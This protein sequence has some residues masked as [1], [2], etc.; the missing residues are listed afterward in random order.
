MASDAPQEFRYDAFI[1]Y[2]HTEPDR[3]WARWLHAALETYRVPRRLV[4]ERG[5]QPRIRR[6][7]RDEEELPASADLSRE[8]DLALE[9]SR[10]LIVICSPNAP[11]S[12]WVNA[13]VQRF[14]NLGRHDRILA[15]L[16]EGEPSESFPRA[17]CEIR[18]GVTDASG[19]A[20]EE[21]EA[22]E[23]LAADVRPTRPESPR[24]LKRMARL[25]L[26][27]CILGCRFDDLR[28]RDQERQNRRRA[29]AVAAM[30]LLLL[31][32]TGLAGWALREAE[33]ARKAE[34]AAETER[35]RATE[36][37]KTA[38]EQRAEARK[39]R[40]AALKAQREA[41]VEAVWARLGEATVQ[42]SLGDR[43][44]ALGSLADLKPSLEKLGLPGSL[45]PVLKAAACEEAGFPMPWAHAI[46]RGLAVSPNGE[47][48]LAGGWGDIELRD[49]ATGRLLRTFKVPG[50]SVDALAFSPDGKRFVSGGGDETV[51]HW[52]T[53]TG[54]L[55]AE[56]GPEKADLGP[57]EHPAKVVSVA[58]SPDGRRTLAA[59]QD[60]GFRLFDADTGN[61]LRTGPSHGSRANFVAFL[62][63]DGTHLE[64]T[65]DGTLRV[66][67]DASGDVLSVCEGGVPLTCAALSPDGTLCL[68][69]SENGLAVLWD[70]PSRRI[71]K[72]FEGQ[73]PRIWA[74][75]FAPDGKTAIVAETEGS[76]RQ[77]EVR[78]ARPLR[79]W[80]IGRLPANGLVFPPS[81]RF[82]LAGHEMVRAWGIEGDGPCRIHSADADPVQAA[83]VSPDGR[84]ALAGDRK[85]A[86][87]LWDLDTG[88]LLR[89][90]EPGAEWILAL[91]FLPG[92]ARFVS[93]A[94][95]G[96]VRLWD[97]ESGAELRRWDAGLKSRALGVG[98]G[99]RRIVT[100]HPGGL[101]V[102]DTEAEA[103]VR[104]I[105]IE[106]EVSSLALFPDGRRIASAFEDGMLRV[107]DLVKPTVSKVLN[108]RQSARVPRLSRKLAATRP[109]GPS[110]TARTYPVNP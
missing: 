3:R 70:L 30:G 33:R 76:I 93:A 41:E 8:I 29:L 6:V 11:K 2:R 59:C 51:R 83:A 97:T 24:Y 94:M 82:F 92:G 107:H 54:R 23:P 22:V 65:A 19:A 104:E 39:Q 98:P 74:V 43:E 79:A 52:E 50:K 40:D 21:I 34:S 53:G 78:T 10:V 9:Q 20:V 103:C 27:A 89:E 105:P 110:K 26:L 57:G 66:I 85:G 96:R 95:D 12:E 90:Y 7:F 15:L 36:A 68:A 32:M 45:L 46:A 67:D 55:I 91:E 42:A 13:E 73:S 100:A 81:G 62:P 99:G 84:L 38:E 44:L 87:F 18:H 108:F 109:E 86:I 17:L 102:W 63:E 88:I 48:L 4:A 5:I 71:V 1:S 35:D 25:R 49:M 60:L 64:G 69:G 61:C 31:A 106:G 77:W 37:R 72:R 56:Q 28:Q 75:A 58:W 101:R 14:R 80:K 47:L 16:I